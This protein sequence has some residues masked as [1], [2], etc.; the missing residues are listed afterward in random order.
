MADKLPQNIQALVGEIGERQVLLRLSILSH[1]RPKWHA[2]R[3]LGESG[4]DVLLLNSG[5]DERICVEVKTRK[6]DIASEA[7]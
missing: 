1:Q 6:G 3:N 5:T 2:F 7:T 4:Y